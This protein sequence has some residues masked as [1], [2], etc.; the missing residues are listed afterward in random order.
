MI[1]VNIIPVPKLESI[2]A[3]CWQL[4]Q[5]DL[6]MPAYQVGD[7]LIGCCISHLNLL[8]CLVEVD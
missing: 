5:H 4:C 2:L 7:E 3:T 6:A 1:R 8:N